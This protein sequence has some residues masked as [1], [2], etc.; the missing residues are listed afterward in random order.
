MAQL[1][2][3]CKN[4]EWSKYFTKVT[5][6]ALNKKPKATKCRTMTQSGSMHMQHRQL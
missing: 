6:T 4:G 2:N 5:M 1:N 3:I